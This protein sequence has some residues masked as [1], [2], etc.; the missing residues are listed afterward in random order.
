MISTFFSSIL[1]LFVR[2]ITIHT[3]AAWRYFVHRFLLN[4]PYS[5]HAFTV[6][7]PLLDHANRPYREAFIA[8]KKQQDERNRKALTHLNAHQQHILEILKAEG[9]SHEE[10]IQDMVS[11]EDIK[12][13]DTDV[14]P[15][16]P[17]YFSNRALNAVI[18]L[19]FWLILLVI[20]I[21]LC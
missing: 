19:L 12:V 7:A 14:F 4:E 21:S 6:N 8:W 17:E 20:T 15:R 1:W 13:I 10:A 18:G 16:N 2:L 9:C 3:G 11:A 5:Y